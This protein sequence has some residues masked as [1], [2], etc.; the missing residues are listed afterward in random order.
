MKWASALQCAQAVSVTR[1]GDMSVIG[2]CRFAMSAPKPGGDKLFPIV[3]CG[4]QM[5]HISTPIQLVKKLAGTLAECGAAKYHYTKIV[6]PKNIAGLPVAQGPEC[7][8]W[9]AGHSAVRHLSGSGLLARADLTM[10]YGSTSASLILTCNYSS[11]LN[12]KPR[13]SILVSQDA[14]KK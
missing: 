7:P 10:R 13:L 4:G 2:E 3:R 1:V 6:L 9:V 14:N 12:F 5:G 8:L 11:V